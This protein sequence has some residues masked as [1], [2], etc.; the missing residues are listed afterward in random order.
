MDRHAAQLDWNRLRAFLATAETGSLSAAARQLGLT[1]PTL[2]RQV[3]A[4]E[5]ALGAVLFER[6]GRGLVLTPTG[7]D[8]LEH[9]RPMAESAARFALVAAGRSQAIEGP[10]RITTTEAYAA[11]VLPPVIARLRAAHPGIQVEIMA[12]N[13][14]ADLLRREA[15]I[16]IRNA[17]PGDAELVARKVGDDRGRPYAAP[18]VLARLDRPKTLQDLAVA[19][20]VGFGDV[21][22]FIEGVRRF[23][24]HLSRAQLPVLADSYLVHWEL[25]RQ[26][27][28]VGFMA[29]AVGDADPAVRRALPDAAPIVFP[30]WLVTHRELHTSRRIRV[31]FDLLA[32]ALAAVFAAG[33]VSSR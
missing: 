20:F 12:T 27:A 11:H 32:D 8:L 28:G 29:E 26:G 3:T 9:L 19:G 31:A 13:R 25:V 16:A 30:V 23:G 10:I 1:Q 2:G 21:E 33:R 24:L 22:A 17:A 6:A 14:T 5:Q 18:A 4:L 7:R 15:D